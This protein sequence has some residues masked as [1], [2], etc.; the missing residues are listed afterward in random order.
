MSQIM[1][2]Q[3]CKIMTRNIF[4][5]EIIIVYFYNIFKYYYGTESINIFYC[6]NIIDR[7]YYKT[8]FILIVKLHNESH[9]MY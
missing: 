6:I 7:I 4:V 1:A 8:S 2:S 9:Q 5:Y 3:M